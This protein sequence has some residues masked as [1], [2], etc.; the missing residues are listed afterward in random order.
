MS[1][2]VLTGAIDRIARGED[3]G[4]DEA[5]RVLREVMMGNASEAET[6]DGVIMGLR[7]REH[8]VEGVQFHPESILTSVGK[9]LLANFLGGVRV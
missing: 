2:P 3:L 4:A 7:H 8:P 9:D 1:N 6:D 5:A